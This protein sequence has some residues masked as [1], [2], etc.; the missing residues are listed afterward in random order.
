MARR[1]A[2]GVLSRGLIS[3]NW[4]KEPLA[5]GDFRAHSPHFQGTNVDAN[6]APVEALRRIADAK[7]IGVAQVAI[8]W[9]ARPGDDEASRMTRPSGGGLRKQ[10]RQL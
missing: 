5:A 7:N 1:F 3:G 4:R 6:L 2:Y 9:V 10:S 8:A